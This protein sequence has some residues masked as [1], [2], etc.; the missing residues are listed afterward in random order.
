[1]KHLLLATVLAGV[2]IFSPMANITCVVVTPDVPHAFDKARAVFIGEVVKITEP[3]TSKPDAPL[4]ERFYRVTF[5]VDYSWKGAGFR[6]F[7]VT[8]LVVL[9]NQVIGDSCFS[10]G[11]FSE[12]R[13]YLV[14]AQETPEKNLI[15]ELGNRTA[16]LAKASDDLRELEKMSHP[17]FKFRSQHTSP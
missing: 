11:A 17:F 15:V 5:K 2:S 3:L 7:G 16:L 1:M 8:E 10:W 12:G 6:E 4:A 14:Y 9:S 13:K